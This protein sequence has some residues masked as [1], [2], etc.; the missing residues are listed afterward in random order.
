M[1]RAMSVARRS[2][3]ISKLNDGRTN[4]ATRPGKIN[5]DRDV[6]LSVSQKL[7]GIPG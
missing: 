3:E 2:A 4:V 7:L 6:E 5:G 1:S